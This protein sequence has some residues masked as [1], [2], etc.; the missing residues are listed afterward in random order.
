MGFG[1][2]ESQVHKLASYIIDED[3]KVKLI[4]VVFEPIMV[5]TI[6]LNELA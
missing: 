5:I 1:F 2:T 6:N 4:V 3:Q